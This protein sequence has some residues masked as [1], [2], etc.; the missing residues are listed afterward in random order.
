MDSARVGSGAAGSVRSP[1]TAA[2]QESGQ[3]SPGGQLGELQLDAITDATWT[4]WQGWFWPAATLATSTSWLS[5]TQLD[6]VSVSHS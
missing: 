5:F 2:T 6:A 1:V 4:T 3:G